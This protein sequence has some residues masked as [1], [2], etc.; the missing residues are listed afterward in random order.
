MMAQQAYRSGDRETGRSPTRSYIAAPEP[1]VRVTI[2]LLASLMTLGWATIPD[3]WAQPEFQSRRFTTSDGVDLH[4]LV[5]GSGPTMVFVPGWTAPAEIWEPQLRHFAAS[6]RVVAL[7]PRSQGRSQKTADGNYLSRRA[8]DIGEL[9]KHLDAAPAVVVAWSLGG[10]EVLIYAQ[11]FG[12][13][14]LR[15]A[16][17]VD[18]FIGMDPDSGEPHPCDAAASMVAGL[19]SDRR[20]FTEEFVRGWYRSNPTEEYLDVMTQASLATPTNT[21]IALTA[22]VCLT[23]PGDWRPALEA[24]NRPVLIV[25]SEEASQAE[26][27]RKRRPDARVEIFKG[28]GHALFVD[29]PE[30]FN[31][32]I[33]EFLARLPEQ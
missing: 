15:A 23:E 5:A 31:R 17:L 9:V 29:A 18:T 28:A 22:S 30:Q 32:V 16:V 10:L 19:Q 12:T 2:V 14:A 4:Y 20:R 33:G 24:L 7:D 8:L 21:A 6:Y 13:D 1:R 3:T 27:V 26:M 25:A 11:E